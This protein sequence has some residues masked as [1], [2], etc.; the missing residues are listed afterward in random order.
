MPE[1]ANDNARASSSGAHRCVEHVTIHTPP[2]MDNAVDGWIAIIEAQFELKNITQSS[3][4][5]FN[6]L[7]HLPPA[8]ISKIP[9]DILVSKDYAELKDCIL[10]T[11]ETSKP[12]M[13]DKLMSSTKL[14]GRPSIIYK[15]SRVLHLS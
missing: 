14:S 10:S 2:F 4:K 13:L 5:F 7:P 12:E 9:K 3:T 11:Y 8:I 6:T 1:T 15:K